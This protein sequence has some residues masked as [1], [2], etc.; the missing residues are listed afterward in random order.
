[1]YNNDV[2]ATVFRER[3]LLSPTFFPVTGI[4]ERRPEKSVDMDI[5]FDATPRTCRLPSPARAP[6]VSPG[7]TRFRTERSFAS[8]RQ[9]RPSYRLRIERHAFRNPCPIA[10]KPIRNEKL[11][12]SSCTRSKRNML[13]IFTF[14]TF[15]PQ[16]MSNTLQSSSVGNVISATR[17]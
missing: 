6:Y 7:P 12:T 5:V 11:R 15:R 8:K 17:A 1:V 2:R 14:I 13:T 16:S 10:K 9:W 3:T 4:N